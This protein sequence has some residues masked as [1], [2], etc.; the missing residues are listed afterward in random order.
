MIR[1]P[2]SDQVSEIGFTFSPKIIR[3]AGYRERY[4]NLKDFLSMGG[5]ST[6]QPITDQRLY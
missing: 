5:I 3:M 2:G 6:A 1:D 4:Q